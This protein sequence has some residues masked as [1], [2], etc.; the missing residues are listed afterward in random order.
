MT[1]AEP[2]AVADPPGDAV[3]LDAEMEYEGRLA[4]IAVKRRRI[5]ELES[6]VAGVRAALARFEALCQANVGDLLADLRHVAEAIGLYRSQVLELQR[7]LAAAAGPEIAEDVQ[8]ETADPDAD[9]LGGPAI[10][11]ADEPPSLA[12]ASAELRRLYR[13]LAKRCHPDFACDDDDRTRRQERMLQINDAFRQRDLAA[14]RALRHEVEA[15]DPAFP[16]RP[17]AERLAW[18]VIELQRLDARLA[19]LRAEWLELRRSDVHRLWKRHEAG[20][21]IFDDLRDDLE[22]QLAVEADRLDGLIAAWRE[23][24]GERP[25]AP[26]I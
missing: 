26:V 18:A 20:E 6:D 23:L 15:D 7:D 16:R 24:S 17:L 5:G 12:E 9:P 3:S 4:E 25:A 10:D 2:I 19:V 21:P 8:G 22:R 13:D 11:L 14:L 1:R